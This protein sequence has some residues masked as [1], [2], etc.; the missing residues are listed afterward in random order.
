MAEV[1]REPG[2][3]LDQLIKRFRKQ[4]MNEGLWPELKKRMYYI[5]PSAERRIIPRQNI[6]KKV[7]K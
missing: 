5:K 2:E 6:K 1:R 3:T 4:C 7:M